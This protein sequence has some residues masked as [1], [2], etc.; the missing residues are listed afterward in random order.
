M[1]DEFRELH[2]EIDWLRARGNQQ[3]A[4]I[5]I[6]RAQVDRATRLISLPAGWRSEVINIERRID[7]ATTMAIGIAVVSILVVWIPVFALTARLL[8]CGG[9]L[10]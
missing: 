10:K 2:A 9:S 1:R 6:L 8:L 3:Q 4:E 5:A 7:S